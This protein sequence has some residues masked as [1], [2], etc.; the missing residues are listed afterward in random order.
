V[1]PHLLE[2]LESKGPGVKLRQRWIGPFEVQE[3]VSHNAYRLKLPKTFPS[4]NIINLE[5]L[6]PYYPTPP[7]FGKQPTLPD[8]C[9]FLQEGESYKVEDILDHKFNRCQ[10]KLV[11]KIRFKGYSSL[12][13]KWLTE[14]ELCDVSDLLQAYQ[15]CQNL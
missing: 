6:R 5:H 14:R 3:H 10:R 2:W 11:Y 9:Q 4:S 13:D 1:N 8:T 15:V 7:C 12:A